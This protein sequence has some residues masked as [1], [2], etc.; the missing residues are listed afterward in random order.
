M[1]CMRWLLVCLAVAT[2]LCMW[3]C[4]AISAGFSG[5]LPVRT[6][7]GQRYEAR[8]P[9]ETTTILFIGYDHYDSGEMHQLHGYSSGG[10]ADFLLLV[11]L[12]H[13]YER[14]HM[15]QID[16]DT[17]ARVRVTD[18]AGKQHERSA[19]QICL[20]HAYG[21]TREENNANTVLAVEMLLGIEAPDDGVGIDMYIAM[22]ISGIS[23]L[24]DLLGGVT[25]TIGEDLTEIDPAMK[26][27]AVITLTGSQA[28]K[29]CRARQGVGDQ[30]NTSRMA[31]QR[32]YMAAA[33]G[34]L[35]SMVRRN[36]NE[37]RRILDGM[38]VIYD[39]TAG[40]NEFAS[41]SGGTAVGDAQG[42]WVMTNA[43]SRT[44]VNE[45]INAADY[46]LLPIDTLPGKHSLGSDGYVRFDLEE[47]AAIRWTLSIFY[48]AE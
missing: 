30:T 48:N 18:A 47:N 38:G 45:M 23:R 4:P 11:V 13:R 7:E 32:Q 35:I 28:E 22:D 12:D 15:L 27:G 36:P 2:L 41:S 24:N 44:I 42:H 3:L 25:V 26:P 21:D 29:F 40:A 31:R 6:Y 34:Q 8:P 19:L 9:K 5:F 1:R 37:S 17:M 43:L 33:G 10:Q 16:R 14:I 20:A 39:Q 46:E